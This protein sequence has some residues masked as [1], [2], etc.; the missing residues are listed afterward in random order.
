MNTKEQVNEI[1]S[2][3][4]KN[5]TPL[6]WQFKYVFYDMKIVWK[7]SFFA[8]LSSFF[9][10]LGLI[11]WLGDFERWYLMFIVIAFFYYWYFFK[12]DITFLKIHNKELYLNHYYDNERD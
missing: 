7:A 5:E 2:R 4:D 3:I 1:L 6:S 10:M 12:K 9:I 11:I 8:S